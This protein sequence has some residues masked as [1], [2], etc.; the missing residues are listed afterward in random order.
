MSG[1]D[2]AKRVPFALEEQF[3]DRTDLMECKICALGLFLNVASET[4]LRR[5]FGCTSLRCRTLAVVGHNIHGMWLALT[6]NFEFSRYTY[7]LKDQNQRTMSA[8]E[9]TSEESP[10]VDRGWCTNPNLASVV[11]RVTQRF[12]QGLGVE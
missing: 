12:E 8:R 5:L 11:A 6:E 2:D 1:L 7:L 10:T 4:P 3:D 9:L